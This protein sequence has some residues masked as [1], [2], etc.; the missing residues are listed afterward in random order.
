[1]E[2]YLSVVIHIYFAKPSCH[3]HINRI[4][5]HFISEIKISVHNTLHVTDLEEA[6]AI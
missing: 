6:T 1:M 4:S 2:E 5:R 3:L